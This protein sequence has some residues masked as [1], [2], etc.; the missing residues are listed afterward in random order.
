MALLRNIP[1]VTVVLV[2]MV[3][4]LGWLG[5]DIPP[6]FS[7]IFPDLIVHPVPAASAGGLVSAGDQDREV[8]THFMS[9]FLPIAREAF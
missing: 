8:M 2:I 7:L 4:L 6:Q 5:L 3:A 1:F 9:S